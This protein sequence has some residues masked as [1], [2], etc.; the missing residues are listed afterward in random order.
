LQKLYSATWTWTLQALPSEKS[1]TPHTLSD[2]H[3]ILHPLS[4]ASKATGYRRNKGRSRTSHLLWCLHIFATS[5]CKPQDLD[6]L[7]SPG[8]N[9]HKT[10][11]GWSQAL[12]MVANPHPWQKKQGQ[13]QGTW[14]NLFC[15]KLC[16]QKSAAPKLSLLC[17]KVK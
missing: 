8:S 10:K 11:I 13:I 1:G 4:I 14:G 16:L 6:S 12:K 15:K 9:N 7:R 2:S 17:L 5:L 3:A